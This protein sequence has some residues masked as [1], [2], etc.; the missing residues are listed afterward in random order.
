[1]NPDYVSGAIDWFTSAT[2]K[3]DD[4][5]NFLDFLPD[6]SMDVA[7]LRRW[8]IHGRDGQGTVSQPE[9]K[10][11]Q[12]ALRPRGETITLADGTDTTVD[13]ADSGV[14]QVG[15]LLRCEGEVMRITALTSATVV[16]VTRGYSGTAAAHAAKLMYSL[17]M[18]PSDNATPGEAVGRVPVELTNYI[19]AFETPVEASWLQMA[20][21]TT[22][23]G[24]TIDKQLE[25]VFTEINRQLARA[26]LYGKKKKDTSGKIFAMDG[27]ITQITS[28][29]TNV[30][31]AL[32]QAAIDAMLLNI[33]NAGGNPTTLSVSPY[34]KQK[35]DALDNN[36]QLLGK[37]EHTGGGLITET[38]QSGILGSP[39]DVVVDKSLLDDQLLI[40][41]DEY[42]EIGPME[43]NGL[44]GSWGT[45]DASANGQWGKKKVVRGVFYNKLHNEK[46]NGYLYGLT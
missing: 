15:E 12:T 2:D 35:L 29:V 20:S 42:V 38:W 16:T 39:L 19:Q 37:K 46:A 9:F 1:M 31:G 40:T 36:K 13:V 10:W 27:I 5:Q 14:Y 21:K 28:N 17:G 8:G 7:L 6:N 4:L 30:G 24:N 26:V 44:S 43:G 32:T 41:D 11:Q 23:G 34:Q 18:A 22:D 25:M 45:Y 3:I 33:V